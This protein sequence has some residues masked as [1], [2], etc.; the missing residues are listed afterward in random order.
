MGSLYLYLYLVL[1]VA[2]LPMFALPAVLTNVTSVTSVASVHV[3]AN[4]SQVLCS[5]VQV[6]WARLGTADVANSRRTVFVTAAL[7]GPREK[8]LKTMSDLAVPVLSSSLGRFAKTTDGSHGQ[9]Y[10]F[11]AVGWQTSVPTR[12]YSSRCSVKPTGQ[13][14][15]PIE[16]FHGLCNSICQWLSIY[17]ERSFLCATW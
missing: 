17:V 4:E 7:T 3:Y 15:G 16:P 11:M 13:S 5:G 9:T 14:C 8:N 6:K 1:R 12:H 2:R 10:A